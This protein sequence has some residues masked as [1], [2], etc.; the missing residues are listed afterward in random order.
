MND[1]QYRLLDPHE[2]IRTGDEIWLILARE[3]FPVLEIWLAG[4]SEVEHRTVRR[5]IR[6]QSPGW[7][8]VNSG[9]VA[10]PRD[11]I[12]D[13]EGVWRPT[14]LY[15]INPKGTYGF[16]HLV[17][18]RIGGDRDMAK[19]LF[20]FMAYGSD[21]DKLYAAMTAPHPTPDLLLIRAIVE[22]AV[23]D[24]SKPKLTIYGPCEEDV[25]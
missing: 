15:A 17:R 22:A 1:V 12:V 23:Y 18:R 11:E 13:L 20:C 10:H 7:R 24:L 16:D 25:P 9:E 3:W 4:N 19:E 8:W 2:I 14:G 21:S 6:I 5:R